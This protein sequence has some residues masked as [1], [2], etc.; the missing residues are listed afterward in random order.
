MAPLMKIQ[1]ERFPVEVGDDVNIT[2][3]AWGNKGTFWY[4]DGKRRAETH[5]VRWIPPKRCTSNSSLVQ[6]KLHIRNVTKTDHG[7]YTCYTLDFISNILQKSD[8]KLVGE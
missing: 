1:S 6:G 7:V 8:I 4:K 2:C 3:T 5:R